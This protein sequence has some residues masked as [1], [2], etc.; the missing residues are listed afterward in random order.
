MSRPSGR[1]LRSTSRHQYSHRHLGM[2]QTMQSVTFPTDDQRMLTGNLHLPEDFDPAGS[3]PAIVVAHPAGGVKE[4]TAG[5]Y[6]GR[7]AEQGFIALPADASYQGESGG[8][9]HFLEDPYARVE[10]VRAAVDYL[11]S[12][13]YVDAE[14]IGALG[15]CAGGGYTVNAT[16]TDHR[17]KALATVSAFNMGTGFRRDW[18][19]LN[20]DSAAA[21]V[22]DEAAKQRTAEAQGADPATAP[23]VPAEIDENTNRDMREAHE[24]YLTSRA[25]HPNTKNQ[26]LFTRS[27][28]KIA[29]FDAFHLV[30]DLLTQPILIVAGSEA[31]SLWHSTELYSRARSPKKL[32]VVDGGTH[33]DFYDIPQYVD[34]AV[35]E[36][37]PFFNENLAR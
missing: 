35:A 27:F 25:Q 13:D 8:A 4:Q 34:R 37:T 28:S 36:A 26:F 32:V 21:A 3:Y 30:E 10:D 29:A 33:M 6:A 2:E 31:G 7:L 24:Y 15:I 20:P 11:Q 14:R 12:L 1:Y 9:P 17:I 18:Y 23:Y 16:M 5:L 19:G 22:L